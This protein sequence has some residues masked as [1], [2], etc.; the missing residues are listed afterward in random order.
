MVCNWPGCPAS[1]CIQNPV[2]EGYS[3]LGKTPTPITLITQG[4]SQYSGTLRFQVE[5]S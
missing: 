3:E 4:I 2:Q 1:I 5:G